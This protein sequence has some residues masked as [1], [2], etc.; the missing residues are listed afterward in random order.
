[1]SSP[2]TNT[3]I[4]Y[5]HQSKSSTPS[6]QL[7]T[8]AGTPPAYSLPPFPPTFSE[9]R[10]SQLLANF[11]HGTHTFD[12]AERETPDERRVSFGDGEFI[13]GMFRLNEAH[14]SAFPP[15]HAM[16]MS[17]RPR[18]LSS[19]SLTRPG[20]GFSSAASSGT[21][22]P[23]LTTPI[24]SSQP[25]D[26]FFPGQMAKP[27]ATIYEEPMSRPQSTPLQSQSHQDTSITPVE[28]QRSNT[29]PQKVTGFANQGIEK[30]SFG[31][32]EG[33]RHFD[34]SKEPRLLGIL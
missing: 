25:K 12:R 9:A 22:T 13:S 21:S 3:S 18:F 30:H 16:A 26:H 17:G 27:Q 34:P 24:S 10:L 15:Q 7:V 19:L 20:F 32:H 29:A 11:D 33:H 31:H 1:M 14:G 8:P 28:M 6:P 2:L 5:P 23:T 4:M